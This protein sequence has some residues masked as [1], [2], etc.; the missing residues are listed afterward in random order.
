MILIQRQRLVPDEIKTRYNLAIELDGYIYFEIRKG[1]YGLKEAGII[2][3][4]HL[5][6]NLLPLWVRTAQTH[7]RNMET[8][9]TKNNI[10]P[11]RRR[12]RH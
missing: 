5:V 7:A 2:A 1:R 4:K 9:T 6:K 3:Y 10:H 11:L 8:Q 12:F